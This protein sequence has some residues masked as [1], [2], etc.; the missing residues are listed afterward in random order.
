MISA[1]LTSAVHRRRAA[2]HR[3]P[4]SAGAAPRGGVA[5]LS[6]SFAGSLR[7]EPCAAGSGTDRH[8]GMQRAVDRAQ[9]CAGASHAVPPF[10]L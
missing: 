8:G 1:G 2:F 3:Q 9:T 7:R 4:V 6:V 5:G 10:S